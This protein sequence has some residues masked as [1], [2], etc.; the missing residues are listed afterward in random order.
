MANINA[1]MRSVFDALLGP[2]SGLSPWVGLTLVS[3]VVGV[4]AL[5][6]FKYTSNQAALEAI[7]RRI[8]AG[9]FE[10]RLFND[11]LRAILRASFDILRHNLT[12]FRLSLAPVVWLLVPLALVFAQLQF[13]YGY[14]GLHLGEAVLV[15]ADLAENWKEAGVADGTG[16]PAAELVA[17]TGVRVEAGPHWTP[18]KGELAWRIAAEQVGRYELTLR[19][20]GESYTKTLVAGNGLA[21][22][23]PVRT[24]HGFLAQL[25]YPAEPPLP[26]D[27]PLTAIHV[28]YPEGG[29]GLFGWA[30]PWW[31]IFLLLTFVV[32]FALRGPLGVTF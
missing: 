25:L 11:D 10:I 8:H 27:S 21:R 28:A 1:F 24:D 18:E 13:H 22:R 26:A 29:I 31:L 32:A 2:F 19:L 30:A 17:P 5:F 3:V 6:V 12:Y 9:L 4:V 23:S 7:K 15:R 20:G 16:R 14:E